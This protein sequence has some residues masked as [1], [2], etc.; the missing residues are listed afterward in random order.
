MDPI[1]ARLGMDHKHAPARQGIGDEFRSQQ[2][3][4]QVTRQHQRPF[5]VGHPQGR[6]VQ[7]RTQ[8]ARDPLADP[9]R[10]ATDLQPVHPALIDVESQSARRRVLRGAHAG[11]EIAIL[12]VKLLNRRGQGR[13]RHLALRLLDMPGREIDQRGGIVEGIAA[14]IGDVGPVGLGGH[15][16]CAGRDR[17][18]C[19]CHHRKPRSPAAPTSQSPH[20]HSLPSGAA[21]PTPVH[22]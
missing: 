1:A 9:V 22:Q 10:H 17:Q 5:E 6:P 18:P 8:V 14:K 11:Q 12:P 15:R 16:C 13:Q 19:A 3:A 7:H 4:G 2:H 20:R 21:H